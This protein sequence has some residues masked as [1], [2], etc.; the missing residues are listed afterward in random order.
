MVPSS[1]HLINRMPRIVTPITDKE[2]VRHLA[3]L[4]LQLTDQ[5]N[6]YNRLMKTLIKADLMVSLAGPS[7]SAVNAASK[8]CQAFGYTNPSS[9]AR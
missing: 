7:H 8:G 2:I 9:K 5:G 4:L 6:Q 3:N 1:A